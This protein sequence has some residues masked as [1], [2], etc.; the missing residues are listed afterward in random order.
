MPS[1]PSA[2]EETEIGEN[3]YVALT[4]NERNHLTEALK[5]RMYD[6]DD[7]WHCALGKLGYGY[8]VGQQGPNGEVK[9]EDLREI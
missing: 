5:V 2:Q 3:I 4:E 9:E 7:N 8:S 1:S 6:E